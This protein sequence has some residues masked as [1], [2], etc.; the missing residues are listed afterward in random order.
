[1]REGTNKAKHGILVVTSQHVE[2]VVLVIIASV[3][4]VIVRIH[5]VHRTKVISITNHVTTVLDTVVYHSWQSDRDDPKLT[6]IV[7]DI[8][9]NRLELVLK[10]PFTMRMKRFLFLPHFVCSWHFYT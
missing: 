5:R 10:D 6:L 9:Q 3:H 4:S 1:M 7:L 8:F 2:L